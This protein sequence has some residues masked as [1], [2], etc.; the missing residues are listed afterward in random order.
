M[1]RLFLAF[2][3]LCAGISVNAQF[4][5]PPIPDVQSPTE[6]PDATNDSVFIRTNPDPM[7]GN[8]A[9]ARCFEPCDLN[10][11]HIVTYTEAEQATELILS[12]GGRKNII[13][14]YDFLKHFPNLTHLDVGN[15]SLV[16]LD[17]SMTP[18]LEELNLRSA[19]RL[20]RIK[21]A[22]G[23]HPHI[24]YPNNQDEATVTIVTPTE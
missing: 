7:F 19:L 4:T 2:F 22:E 18:R 5:L 9:F 1:K 21:L 24:V 23:C 6:H 11:D 13:G 10:K 16:E 14:N 20:K 8:T 12:H 3:V 15:C 17:L